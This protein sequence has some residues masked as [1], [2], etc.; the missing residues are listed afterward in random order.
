[1]PSDDHI[2]IAVPISP[3]EFQRRRHKIISL[4]AGVAVVLGLASYF[5]YRH[6]MDPIRAREAYDDAKRQVAVTRYPQAILACS[7]AI[8]LKPDYSDAY[9]LRAQAYAAQRELEPAETDFTHV[10]RLEPQSAR[11]YSGR[12]EVY[13]LFKDY[14]KAIADC[15]KA[16]ELDGT[17]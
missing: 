17:N 2:S 15:G 12:C 5:L 9:L 1:M 10:I 13:Y 14:Q 6:Y 3:E 8:L 16:I 4:C 7:T 11:G